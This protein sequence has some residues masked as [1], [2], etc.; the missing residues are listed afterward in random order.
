MATATATANARIVKSNSKL[1]N[2]LITAISLSANTTPRS[3]TSICYA[4]V[5]W[6]WAM[7][8]VNSFADRL[9]QGKELPGLRLS[10]K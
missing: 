3:R 5:I 8:L 10:V 4:N 1:A 2:T 6:Y 9:T 7:R